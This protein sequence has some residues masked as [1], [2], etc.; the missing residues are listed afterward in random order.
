MGKK[1][2]KVRYKAH[3]WGGKVGTIYSV[4]GDRVTIEF[5]KR[6]FIEV[7]IDEIEYV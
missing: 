5:S 6:D 1:K 2:V 4:N 7:C 3:G